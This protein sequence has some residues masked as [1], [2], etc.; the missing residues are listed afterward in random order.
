MHDHF[1]YHPSKEVPKQT[2]REPE[3]CPIVP[4]LHDLQ[5]I[6]FEV[7]CT[8]KIH[9]LKRLHR[10]FV[11]PPVLAPILLISKLEIMFDRPTRVSSFFILPGR[12]PGCNA[13]E[14]HENW[15]RGKDG[16]EEPCE[17][18]TTDLPGKVGGN[19]G[20]QGEK[21]GIGKALAPRS[22]SREGSILN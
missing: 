19:E 13:P 15:Y 18:A 1:W 17:N 2:N 12:Y 5:R 7:H 4:V 22:V 20:D 9:L 6:A 21:N 16:D 3:I 11:L 10:Y 8:V 14:G